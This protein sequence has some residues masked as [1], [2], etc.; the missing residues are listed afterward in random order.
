MQPSSPD[1]NEQASHPPLWLAIT[2]AA[3]A[4]GMGWGIRGQYG[5]E[6]GAM[7]AGVL[8]GLVVV[9]LF[10]PRA[11]SLAAARAVALCALGI[12]IGGSETYG[13]T[14]GLTQNAE[15]IGSWA[16]LRWGM[17]GLAIKGGT[18]VSFAG[19]LLGMGLSDKKYGLLELAMLWAGVFA[20]FFLGV[21]LLNTPFD[22]AN[23]QLPKLYFSA[24]WY[25]EPDAKSLEP[26]PE[27]WGGLLLALAALVAY[28]GV[29]RKDQLAVRLA[30]WGFLGGALGFPG[31]QCL[32]AFHAWNVDWFR[33]GWFGGYDRQVNWWNFMETTFGAVWGAV[34]AI[35]LWLNRR[36]I[37][38]E[39]VDPVVAI[40]GAA[41]W[42]F[43]AV[44]IA[45]LVAWNFASVPA[46][47]FFADNGLTMIAIPL[48]MVVGGRWWP[49]MVTLP[50]VLIPIAGKTVREE[51]HYNPSTGPIAGYIIYL[52]VPLLIATLAAFLLA[53]RFQD[54]PSGRTFSMPALL[55]ATWIYFG[56][57]FAFFRFP[58]PWE[59]WTSRTPNGLVYLICSLFLTWVALK[60]PPSCRKL[61]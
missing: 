38:A 16:A 21:Y 20:C 50:I 60:L 49:Y 7:L 2:A 58:W 45:A 61:S 6:T 22:P 1:L 39:Q 53:R 57:N 17:L 18:W 24:D 26:R 25:W 44:H 11:T 15:V 46:L 41:E 51:V 35:G 37:A 52:A 27:R 40:G 56:L 9:H 42:I 34:L 36:L 5:H 4:G 43:M 13:Q 12:S 30:A 29:I 19:A 14:V 8:V 54:R 55:V 32:Q 23:H 33:Q 10:S 31:G 3:A 48:L 28:L 47:D 59:T